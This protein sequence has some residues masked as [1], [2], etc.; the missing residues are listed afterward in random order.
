MRNVE[1]LEARSDTSCTA[2][3]PTVV[4]MEQKL[5]ALLRKTCTLTK[6]RMR[7]LRAAIAS[8]AE[9]ATEIEH[10]LQ[11]SDLQ[12][13]DSY[14]NRCGILRNELVALRDD[15]SG[16]LEER[17]YDTYDTLTMARSY[18]IAAVQCSLLARSSSGENRSINPERSDLASS[19]PA[20]QSTRDTDKGVHL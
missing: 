1:A 9:S 10:A 4:V 12:A 7:Q 18:I 16:C 6:V 13:V 19:C 5:I 2:A 8:A 17:W 3:D 11:A 14:A 15:I 20:T